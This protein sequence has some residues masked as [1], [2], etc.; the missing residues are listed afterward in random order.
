MDMLSE[1]FTERKQP[2]Q[3]ERIA[4]TTMLGAESAASYGAYAQSGV[5]VAN[6]WLTAID[7][8]QRKTHEHAHGQVKPLYK[9]LAA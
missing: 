6:E 3:L 4:R 1:F 2:Y 9:P 5:V 7:G 8:R